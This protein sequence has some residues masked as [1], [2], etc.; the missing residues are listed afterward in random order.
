METVTVV[1]AVCGFG[2]QA[3]S[4]EH[5]YRLWEA[6]GK[7]TG[8]DSSPT[9]LEKIGLKDC[10][11]ALLSFVCMICRSLFKVESDLNSFI[12]GLYKNWSVLL[13]VLFVLV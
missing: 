4:K 13:A 2:S 7:V 12:N 3:I 5:C 8:I 10:G 11:I 1:C 6:S 9:L